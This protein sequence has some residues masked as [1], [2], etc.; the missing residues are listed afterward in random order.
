MSTGVG[1]GEAETCAQSSVSG[2]QWGFPTTCIP[3]GWAV[4]SECCANR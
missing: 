1:C 2:E 4:K 3:E